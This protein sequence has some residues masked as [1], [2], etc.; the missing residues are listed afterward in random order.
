MDH[1]SVLFLWL[2]ILLSVNSAFAESQSLELGPTGALTLGLPFDEIDSVAVAFN[3]KHNEYFI[4]Y[5]Y[6]NSLLAPD[7]Q[8]HAARISTTGAY[9]ANYDNISAGLNSRSSLSPAI[10]YDPVLDRYLVAWQYGLIGGGNLFSNIYARFIP[11]DGP[12]P[13]L[14]AWAVT[15]E[16]NE[17]MFAPKIVLNP[18]TR[19]F[20]ILASRNYDDGTAHIETIGMLV[21]A[22]SNGGASWSSGY[23][24]TIS[25]PSKFVGSHDALYN[26]ERQEFVIVYQLYSLSLPAVSDIFCVR[27]SG[28]NPSTPGLPFGVA[29]WPGLEYA[30]HISFN[31]RAKEYYVTWNAEGAGDIAIYGRFVSEMGVTGAVQ[32]L[33][34]IIVKEGNDIAYVDSANGYLLSWTATNTA[35]NKRYLW[36]RFMSNSGK[37][38]PGMAL[39]YIGDTSVGVD[40]VAGNRQWSLVFAGGEASTP[41]IAYHRIISPYLFPWMLFL[42]A[43]QSSLSH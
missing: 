34:D 25:D 1:K 24:V 4:V 22:D 36:G 11:Y 37:L 32:R 20:L 6:R 41:Q 38:Y 7:N 8:L 35:T 39:N 14:T 33:D 31:S 12:D 29:A 27:L 18:D 5:S 26:S 16:T 3:T 9:I 28:I 19:K 10:S 42:P 30:P 17:F 40:L 2:I 15:L 43:I 13:L 23:D 21:D